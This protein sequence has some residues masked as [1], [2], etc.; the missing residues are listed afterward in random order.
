M[1]RTEILMHSKKDLVRHMNK[2]NPYTSVWTVLSSVLLGQCA[3]EWALFLRVTACSGASLVACVPLTGR[4]HQIRKHLQILGCS[5]L[6]DELYACHASKPGG[7][8]SP[9]SELPL[10]EDLRFPLERPG[11]APKNDDRL[12]HFRDQTKNLRASVER[13]KPPLS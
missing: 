3:G 11:E 6:R 12:A 13:S 2:L 5:I 4:T 7:R 8:M 1:S 10:R 9:V